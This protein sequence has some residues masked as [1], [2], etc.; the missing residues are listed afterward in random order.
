MTKIS[1]TA[2]E[3]AAVETALFAYKIETEGYLSSY[4]SR[5]AGHD[6][7]CPTARAVQARRHEEWASLED[8]WRMINTALA[9]VQ[10]GET[11]LEIE[12]NNFPKSKYWK[13]GERVEI[14]GHSGS[15]PDPSKNRP[16]T[17]VR[18]ENYL[19]SEDR[20]IVKLDDE[21]EP[22]GINPDVLRHIKEKES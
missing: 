22:R 7:C 8:R 10:H 12:P 1:F 15:Y 18:I 16:G 14:V 9:K 19:S 13:A 21:T 20:L 6:E 4:R 11:E 2:D 17:V 3:L 5:V